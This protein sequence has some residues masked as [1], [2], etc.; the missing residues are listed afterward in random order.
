MTLR[1]FIR[2]ASN[3]I[4]FPKVETKSGYVC[5]KKKSDTGEILLYG[6]IGESFWTEGITAAKFQKDLKA[7]GDVKFIDLRINSDGGDVFDGRAIYALLA[8]HPATVTVYIDGL[9]ASIA[10]TIAMVGK[11]IVMADGSFIMIHNPWGGVMGDA[12]EMRRVASL[13]DQVTDTVAN[14]YAARSGQTKKKCLDMMDEETW[15]TAEDSLKLGFCTEVSEPVKVAAA[16]ITK[17]EIYKHLPS[18][19]RPNRSIAEGVKQRVAALVEK[20]VRLKRSA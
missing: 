1:G 4:Q 20:H 12:K 5:N 11:K 17:P 3:V 6:V 14:T 18:S 13:L 10:S 15:M 2:M 9:A 8:Q 19:L 7:L 16:V